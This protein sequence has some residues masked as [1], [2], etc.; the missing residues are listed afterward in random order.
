MKSHTAFIPT[1][2]GEP[3]NVIIKGKIYDFACGDKDVAAKDDRK[4]EYQQLSSG[5]QGYTCAAKYFSP[6]L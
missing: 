2:Y 6:D 4:N 3:I 1:F 5:L